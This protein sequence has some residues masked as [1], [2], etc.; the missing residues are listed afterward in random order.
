MQRFLVR[1]W[2]HIFASLRF[3]GSIVSIFSAML[4]PQWFSLCASYGSSRRRF[5]CR[6]AE[7][8]FHGLAVQ[9]TIVIPQLQLLDKVL[10]YVSLLQF[11]N[12]VVH[13]PVVPQK[14]IP[15]VLLVRKTIETPQL[16]Y[17]FWWSMPLLCRSCSL[18]VVVRDRCPW[19]RLCR[20]LW[21]FRSSRFPVVDVAVLQRQAVSRQ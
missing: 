19:F 1:Q 7:A 14:Q 9:Q 3:F 12:K 13:T 5:P 4:G 18:L 11:I 20:Y 16:Q 6:G 21:R 8:D 17:V 15:M 2:I 10:D